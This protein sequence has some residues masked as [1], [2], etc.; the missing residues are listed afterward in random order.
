[1]DKA[2]AAELVGATEDQVL[3]V[4][5]DGDVT[6]IVTAAGSKYKVEGDE[7]TCTMGPG[8]EGAAAIEPAPE[9]PAAVSEEADMEALQPVE[10]EE[11]PKAKRARKP[12]AKKPKAAP[13]DEPAID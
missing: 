2:E 3:K 8:S 10:A 4:R 12:R 1:M 5:E 13:A 6:W 7:V 11:A 9:A